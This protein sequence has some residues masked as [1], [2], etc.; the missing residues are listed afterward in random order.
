MVRRWGSG[1]CLPLLFTLPLVAQITIATSQY[2]NAR[3]GA[4]LHETILTPKNVNTR[5]FGK[6][7]AFKVDG[8]VYAQPLYIPNLDLPGKGRHNVLFV[9]TE[10][11]SVYAFDADRPGDPPLWHVSFVDERRSVQ[12]VHGDE[13]Q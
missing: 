3:T 1:A 5:Q 13:L 2:D 7:G 12:P 9:A 10:H 11:D 8:P 4:N 6:V